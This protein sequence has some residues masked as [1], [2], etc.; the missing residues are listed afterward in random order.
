MTPIFE[1]EHRLI[2]IE[3]PLNF[4]Y[5]RESIACT[6]KHRGRIGKIKSIEFAKLIGYEELP[7][8]G[9]GIQLY[10]R[11]FWWLKKHDWD[12]CKGKSIGEVYPKDWREEGRE[13]IYTP[14]IG[15]SPIEAVEPKSITLEGKSKS[16]SWNGKFRLNDKK[17]S[18]P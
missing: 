6:I 2:W 3:N 16:F 12:I 7:K 10:N 18:T 1:K 4:T 14:K 11:R 5:L 9:F 13:N 17:S 8:S 15:L